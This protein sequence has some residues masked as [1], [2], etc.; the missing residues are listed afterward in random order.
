VVA[1]ETIAAILVYFLPKF[2]I[3]KSKKTLKQ[4]PVM[5]RGRVRRVTGRGS[6]GRGRVGGRKF[7]TG[8]KSQRVAFLI[9]LIRNR[10]LTNP[11]LVFP[12]LFDHILTLVY[13]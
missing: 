5:M 2:V 11:P 8:I 10:L 9:W 13:E 6:S 12:L 4:A 1:L 7:I 3:I